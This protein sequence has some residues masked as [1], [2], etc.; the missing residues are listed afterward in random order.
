MIDIETISK[1]FAR[2]VAASFHKHSSAGFENWMLSRLKYKVYQKFK[3]NIKILQIIIYPV[4]DYF[5]EHIRR[6]K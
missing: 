4:C 1:N 5:R 2:S 6:T 3:K